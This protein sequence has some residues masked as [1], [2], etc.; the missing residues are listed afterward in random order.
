MRDILKRKF[1]EV[2]EN[3]C[4]SSSSSSPSLCSPASSEWESDREGSSSESQDFTPHSPASVSS[5]P[6]KF[7]TS[8]CPLPLFFQIM[9]TSFLIGLFSHQHFIVSLI[10]LQQKL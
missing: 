2:E 5:S 6:S 7:P 4:Y 9:Q 1:A 3:P 10:N 8:V